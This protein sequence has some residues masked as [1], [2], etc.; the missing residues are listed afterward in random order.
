MPSTRA[1]PQNRWRTSTS[2]SGDPEHGVDQRGQ[3]R[4]TQREP[5]RPAN[6]GGR[7]GLEK[8]PQTAQQAPGATGPRAAPR[9]ARPNQ[10]STAPIKQPAADRP[11]PARRRAA[12]PRRVAT[13][14]RARQW[15]CPA[16]QCRW[17]AVQD[18]QDQQRRRQEH[19]RDDQRPVAIAAFDLAEDIKRR[20][21]G[22][23]RLVA[24]HHH[25]A[26]KLA[27]GPGKRHRRPGQD[28]RPKR[29]QSHAAKGR[30]RAGTQRR[31]RFFLR[32][33]PAPSGPAARSGSRTDRSR[34][35]APARSPAGGRSLPSRTGPG[36]SRQRSTDQRARRASRP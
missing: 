15:P 18:E 13:V 20:R 31:G 9:S 25:H 1:R 21:L 26:A 7:Q 27:Q 28:R 32:T 22:R 5:E 17:I 16:P 19:R 10:P 4:D 35:R 30:P 11:G 23:Q 2:A 29:R 34:T 36:S 24:G 8:R 12:A 33:D 6:L 3:R 14:V